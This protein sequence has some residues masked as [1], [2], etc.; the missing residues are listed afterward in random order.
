[1]TKDEFER[2]SKVQEAWVKVVRAIRV[3][4]DRQIDEA[5]S[6]FIA[7]TT[8]EDKTKISL[9]IIKRIHERNKQP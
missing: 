6:I 5:L 1:M 7:Q 8:P 2:L 9:E 3:D 4:M